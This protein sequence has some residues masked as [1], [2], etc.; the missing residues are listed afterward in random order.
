[1]NKKAA[2]VGSS[3]YSSEFR[4]LVVVLPSGLKEKIC[5]FLLFGSL[6]RN[7]GNQEREDE[8]TYRYV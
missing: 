4:A 2:K 1:M 6:N 8:L 7:R 3:V 5:R